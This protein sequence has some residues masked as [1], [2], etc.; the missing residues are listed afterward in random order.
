[1]NRAPRE[2]ISKYLNKE[3]IYSQVQI[4][5]TVLVAFKNQFDLFVLLTRCRLRQE[6]VDH[7]R[8]LRQKVDDGLKVF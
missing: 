5:Q 7:V 3:S 8:V 2:T 1:M 6:K 4:V